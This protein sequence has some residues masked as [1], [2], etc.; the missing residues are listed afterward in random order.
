MKINQFE[1]QIYRKEKNNSNFTLYL[2]YIFL[3]N[4]IQGN[5]KNHH[6]NHKLI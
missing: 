5:K 1:N 3:F 2:I 4:L 6:K